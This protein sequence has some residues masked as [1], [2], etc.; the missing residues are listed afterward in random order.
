MK[1]TEHFK[2]KKPDQNDNYNVDDFNANMDVL[3]TALKTISDRIYPVGSIYMSMAATPP[4]K[5]FGGTWEQITDRFIYAAG[6]NKAGATGGE[7]THTLSIAEMPSH[8]HMVHSWTGGADDGGNSDAKLYNPTT[9]GYDTVS[10]GSKLYHIWKSSAF[11]TW[12]NGLGDI[13]GNADYTGSSQA[14]NNMPPYLV[15]YMWK[16]TK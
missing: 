4:D 15:A 13:T 12:G 5:L 3:D 6:S 16:R 7:A 1:L 2:F 8:G 14:H 10:S 9:N 11:K